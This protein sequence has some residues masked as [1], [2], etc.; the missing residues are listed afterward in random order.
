MRGPLARSLVEIIQFFLHLTL[1]AARRIRLPIRLGTN[2]PLNI[3]KSESLAEAVVNTRP[4]Q[5][6]Q[7]VCPMVNENYEPL[8]VQA[9]EIPAKGRLTQC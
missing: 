1:L 8:E 7:F 2:E 4:T 9:S 3:L 6:V 5:V